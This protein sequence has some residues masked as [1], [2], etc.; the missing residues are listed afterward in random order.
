VGIDQH[1]LTSPW[2]Q[3]SQPHHAWTVMLTGQYIPAY[4]LNVTAG[5]QTA[6]PPL[7]VSS[8]S[9]TG[10]YMPIII[11]H[12]RPRPCHREI[13]H[14]TIQISYLAHPY[15]CQMTSRF[16]C[17]GITNPA[18]IYICLAG[19]TFGKACVTLPKCAH[20]GANVDE[21]L[22]SFFHVIVY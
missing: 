8:T 15:Q 12:Q 10:A 4:M 7:I 13:L 16:I 2:L 3:Y 17:P 19:S 21:D 5:Y 1:T 20:A 22:L 6:S 11:R 18:F 9:Q 14:H